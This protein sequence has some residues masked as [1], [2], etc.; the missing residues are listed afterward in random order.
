VVATSA[1]AISWRT[2]FSSALSVYLVA[3]LGLAPLAQVSHL[4][5]ADHGHRFCPEH[6]RIEDTPRGSALDQVAVHAVRLD[7][8]TDG[9]ALSSRHDE[10]LSG[11][12]ACAFLNQ[13]NT[14]H[15]LL[16]AEADPGVALPGPALKTLTWQPHARPAPRSALSCAP[17]TSPPPLLA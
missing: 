7:H 1:A 5:F 15:P 8:A 11:H 16:H 9:S 3:W 6:H 10:P 14:R 4:L 12:A 2:L 13:S 17:K